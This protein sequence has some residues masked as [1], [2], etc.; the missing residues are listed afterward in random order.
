M[1]AVIKGISPDF[2]SFDDATN[3]LV[4]FYDMDSKSIRNQCMCNGKPRYSCTKD[5]NFFLHRGT[6]MLKLPS[7]D[8]LVFVVVNG[9]LK[10]FFQ[11]HFWFPSEQGLGSGY[12]RN[13][14]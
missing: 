11:L 4:F 1:G 10:A 3:L 6:A 5:D 9:N 13:S 12:I 8:I 7:C 2:E 14:P